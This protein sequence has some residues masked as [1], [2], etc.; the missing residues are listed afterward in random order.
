MPIDA[1]RGFNLDNW[2]DRVPVHAA[3]KTYD[4]PGLAANSNRL[5]GVIERDRAR[6]PPLHGKDVVHLQCHIGTDT[7][8][9]T[10]LG[11][12]TVTGYDFSPSA[13]QVARQLAAQA[14]AQITYVEGELYDAIDVLGRHRFDVVYT[15]TGAL[16]WLPDIAGWAKIAAGLLR[17]GGILHLHEHHPVLW[18]LDKRPDDLFVIA[19]PYFETPEPLALDEGPSTYTDGDASTI[20]HTAT[21]EWNHGLG[22]TVQAVIDAG[23]T[24]TMLHELRYCD[25][26]ALPNVME[27]RQADGAAVLRTHP[28]WLPLSYTLQARRPT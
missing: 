18:C 16:N 1:N 14:G 3:S 6:L 11:A 15:G 21:R 25:S 26:L 24:L 28:E 20:T 10:R 19:F 13:L 22:E 23:L 4:L 27:E 7:L 17:P 5:T 2:E 8:S 9:L 12:A